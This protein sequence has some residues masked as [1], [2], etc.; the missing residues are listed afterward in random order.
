M[1]T[2]LTLD[3]DVVFGLERIKT[4]NPNKPFKVVVNE[5]LRKGLKN[6]PQIRQEP[7]VVKSRPLGLRKEIDWDN[8]DDFLHNV[9]SDGRK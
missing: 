5:V 4:A 6:D 3:E 9:E 8:L 2:T 7:F 1:R